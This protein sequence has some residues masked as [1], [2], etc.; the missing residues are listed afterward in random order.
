MLAIPS[1]IARAEI[2]LFFEELNDFC[3]QQKSQ[4][5]VYFGV[6]EICNTSFAETYRAIIDFSFTNIQIRDLLIS[7]IESLQSYS[8]A[9]V[10]Y[11]PFMLNALRNKGN[12]PNNSELTNIAQ[13]ANNNSASIK[14]VLKEH[15][16]YSSLLQPEDLLRFFENNGFMSNFDIKKSNSFQNACIFESGMS[17]QCNFH[18]AFFKTRQ[19]INFENAQIVIYDGFINDVSELNLILNMSMEN[20]TSFLIFSKGASHDV[21]NTCA[22]NLELGK[23]KVCVAEPAHGFWDDIL[24]K[25]KRSLDIPTYGFVTGRLLNN[26]EACGE[27]GVSVLVN[28]SEV[29]LKSKLLD[30]SH[31]ARTTILLNEKTWNKRGFIFDQLN[32]FSSMLQQIATCGF[33]SNDDFL[34]LSGIN[35]N[36]ETGL[37]LHLHPAY[38]VSRSLKEAETLLSKIINIGCLIRLER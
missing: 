15:F 1:Y 32:F 2:D 33:I 11:F 5:M 28:R 6:E 34:E 30:L 8:P 37:D 14:T 3:I 21:L 38:A 35:V 31:S 4:K 16:S 24:P 25:I 26:Y 19:S 17:I 22:V 10:A 13:P 7:Q 9:A 20:N 29:F 23:C 12:V 36:N 18:S 27:L